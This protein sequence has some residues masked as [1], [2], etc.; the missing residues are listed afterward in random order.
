VQEFIPARGGHITRVE[1]IGGKYIYAIKVFTPGDTFNL[2]HGDICQRS[3][4]VELVR[5]IC[6]VDAPK[7]GLKVEGYQPPRDVVQ[8]VERIAGSAGVDVGGIEYIID[9]RDGQLYFYDINALSNFVA[10]ARNVIGFDPHVNL[11]DYLIQSAGTHSCRS[12]FPA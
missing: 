1:V 7:S 3:D 4:G 6:A 10:D 2:C 5:T 11:A 8:A 9:D 12:G